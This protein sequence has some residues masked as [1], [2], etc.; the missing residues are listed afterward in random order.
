M[1]NE[2][3]LHRFLTSAGAKGRTL[4][5]MMETIN[6]VSRANVS[7]TSSATTA[8]AGDKHNN[9]KSPPESKEKGF[10]P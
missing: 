5:A 10:K 8:V 3:K 1:R 9:K 4:N 2:C 6:T 7:S